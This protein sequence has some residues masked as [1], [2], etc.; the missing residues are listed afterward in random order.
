MHEYNASEAPLATRVGYCFNVARAL[1]S[2]HAQGVVHCD[3]KLENVLA[4]V[5]QRSGSVG[6][7]SDF[8]S[9]LLGV[10]ENTVLPQ[11]VAGTPPWNA[12]E[13]RR[14]LRG[15]D[16]F[17]IDVYSFGM[18]MWRF[19]SRSMTLDRLEHNRG[20]D[21]ERL[22]Q[23][24]EELKKSDR[25]ADL[26]VEETKNSYEET[27]EVEVITEVLRKTPKPLAGS[28]CSMADVCSLLASAV[29][30][31]SSL[32]SQDEES[33]GVQYQHNVVPAEDVC[34]DENQS[35]SNNY[36]EGLMEPILPIPHEPFY[37]D[38]SSYACSFS[39]CY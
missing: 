2:L 28:R 35:Q 21:R 1:M 14:S 32:D 19:M 39:F 38:V 33:E 5:T 23:S 6:K 4:C 31:M 37:N 22:V 29:D 20:V 18:L 17:K 11:G 10:N 13:Y 3:V 30:P 34:T 16:I 26:A 7:L 36:V 24:L 9:A 15:L 25:L 27:D 8:G 12:P